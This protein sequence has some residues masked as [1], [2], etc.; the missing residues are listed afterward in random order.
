MLPGNPMQKRHALAGF[1]Q[2]VR[3]PGFG[4]APVPQ[5]SS[6]GNV[7]NS[8]RLGNIQSAEKAA[9]DQGGLPRIHTGKLVQS[10]IQTE[11]IIAA[12]GGLLKGFVKGDGEMGAS[13]ALVGVASTGRFDENLAHGASGD[14]FEMETGSRTYFGCFCQFEPGLI[15]ERRGVQ[16]GTGIVSPDRRRQ[17][18]QLLVSK[19][20]QKVQGAPLFGNRTGHLLVREVFRSNVS[21][22]HDGFFFPVTQCVVRSSNPAIRQGDVGEFALFVDETLSPQSRLSQCPALR[23]A[24]PESTKEDRT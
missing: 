23:V 22:G 19:A 2:F 20:K 4:C 8:G 7:Q 18:A 11:Q 6:F 15:D 12:G 3:E 16:R 1:T 21:C 10:T 17:A 13:A 24:S 14:A 5:N 9:L